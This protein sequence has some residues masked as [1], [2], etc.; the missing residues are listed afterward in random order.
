MAEFSGALLDPE[1]YVPGNSAIG[2]APDPDAPPRLYEPRLLAVN[3]DSAA[4]AIKGVDYSADLLDG[5]AWFFDRV[6]LFPRPL[7]FGSI[8]GARQI[9]VN[10]LNAFRAATRTLSAVDLSA[11]GAGVSLL[12]PPLPVTMVAQEA[13]DLTFEA[14]SD[15]PPSFDADA[16][17]VFDHRS[18]TLRMVGRR[19]VLF[20][21]PPESEVREVLEWRTAITQREDGTEQRQSLRTT[22]RQRIR[23]EVRADDEESAEASELR[24]LLLAFRPFLFGVPVWFELRQVDAPAALGATVLEVD[25]R[26]VD[27]RADGSV[28]V[29]EPGDRSFFDVGVQAIAD[30]QL[31]LAQPTPAAVSADALV[32]PLRF[33]YITRE[34]QFDEW[35]QAIT[36]STIEFE[37]TDN[38]ELAFA[39][40]AALAAAFDVH[41][42][43]G[44]PVLADPSPM[45]GDTLRLAMRSVFTRVD[46]GI[47]VA[48]LLARHP[49]SDVLASRRA[50]AR[51]LAEIR[52]WRALLHWIRGSWGAFYLPTFQR[53]LPVLADF[54]LDA[55]SITVESTNLAQ[56]LGVREPR[57]SLMLE[58]PDRRQF[59]AR[60]TGVVDVGGGAE[61]ISL[62]QAFG[63]TAEIVP[64]ADARVSFLELSRVEGDAATIVHARPGLALIE[65]QTRTLQ[66]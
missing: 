54:Q 43:D 4:G 60:M 21:F 59:F 10:A 29:F 44:L 2:A 52:R 33:G 61:Q 11:V 63:A 39:D 19:L 47:G 3:L 48:Q 6:W 17:L 9:A 20:W 64:A 65:V 30:D 50:R 27:H 34:P 36:D 14:T 51:S 24:T 35:T 45:T 42:E 18:V 40:Q 31:T 38:V 8:I 58:L 23:F 15:G 7:D 46:S 26:D 22:P 37:T 32:V 5:G 62:A 66:G 55:T 49:V 56:F 16:V 12:S 53:D 13:R 25:T 28:L 1:L 41:P 57:R